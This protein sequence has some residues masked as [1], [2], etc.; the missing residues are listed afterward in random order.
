[1]AIAFDA[2]TT[3]TPTASGSFNHTCTGSDRGLFVAVHL[4]TATSGD[5]V[6]VTYGGVSMTQGIT[7]DFAAS[8]SKKAWIFYLANPASGSNS[9]AYTFTG[10]AES[11]VTAISFTGVDQ[12][13]PIGA[14]TGSNTTASGT[15]LT[16]NIT[17]LHANSWILDALNEGG[18][19]PFTPG[20]SQTQRW[21]TATTVNGMTG[22]GSTKTTT[23]AGANSTSWTFT[24]SATTATLISVEIREAV[25]VS[26][27]P[28]FF[29][30]FL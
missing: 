11:V 12:A 8:G 9:V 3:Q 19:T 24:G 26:G 15:S 17:T 4:R 16:T 30:N 14:N 13:N 1:M 2:V 5:S 7:V 20:A 27:N 21:G 29:M 23:T 10:A 18:Q 22:Y 25:A 28:A 6:S